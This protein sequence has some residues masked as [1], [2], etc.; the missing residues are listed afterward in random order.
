MA[1]NVFD[2]GTRGK[3]V[4]AQL[5]ANSER[6]ASAPQLLYYI[7]FQQSRLGCVCRGFCVSCQ[8][9]DRTSWRRSAGTELFPVR[10]RRVG[11]VWSQCSR[12]VLRFCEKLRL[13]SVQ[14]TVLVDSVKDWIW[15]SWTNR[16]YAC[17]RQMLSAFCAVLL[18]GCFCLENA[19][20]N[21]ELDNMTR[22]YAFAMEK[23]LL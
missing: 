8:R 5:T 10:Q 19:R 22:A 3:Y 18:W 4:F 1:S 6:L 20:G 2:S 15:C 16:W 23:S 21:V 9:C 7:L 12:Q 14:K 13:S 17:D 11:F